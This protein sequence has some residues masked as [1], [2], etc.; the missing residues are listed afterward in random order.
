[1][2]K[3]GGA[4]P[5]KVRGGGTQ[6]GER[7]LES[8]IRLRERD[9]PSFD[10][11]WEQDAELRFVTTSGSTDARG[12]ITPAEHIGKR[13]WE[14]P[15]TEIVNQSW[16]EHRAV[17]D[18][19]LPFRDLLLRRTD[20]DG[21]VHLVSVSGRPMF[22][23]AARFGGYRGIA[24]DVTEHRRVEQL[25]DLEHAVN[26]S[27][28]EA[29][30]A[31]AGLEG[32]IRAVCAVTQWECGRYFRVDE[33]DDVLRFSDAWGIAEPQIGR[34]L[35]ISRELVY[36][37]DEGL[38][39]FAWRSG[40][41]VW[42]SDV[43]KD[44]RAPGSSR[45]AELRGAGVNG[46]FVFPVTAD[47]RTVGV[48]SFGSRKPRTPEKQLLDAVAVIGREL[49]QFLQR[50]HAEQELRSKVSLLSAT[51]EST[52][53]GI[54]VVAPDHR[55]SLFNRRFVEMWG[56]PEEIIASRD[57]ARALE[58]V[59]DQV[60]HPADFIAKIEELYARPGAESFDTI[61]F[62]DGRTFERYSRPQWVA[63]EPVGRVWSFRDVTERKRAE[64]RI[65]VL[66]YQDSLTELP[67]RIL[68]K[69]RIE[70]AT[71]RA[72]R[73]H[74]KVALLFLDIDHFKTI[75]DSLG[76]VAGDA[77]LKTAAVRAR[78]CVRETDT[79]SRQGG[80]EFLIMLTDL[81]DSDAATPVVE[82]L[83]EQFQVPFE[84]EGNELTSS[85]S[86]GVAIYPD[87]GDDFDTLLKKADT[88]MY[89]AKE[90]GR[91]TYRFFDAQMN[92]E[93]VEHLRIRNDL[94]SAVK[95]EE[96]FLH[97][98]PQIDLSSGK[99][100]AAEALVRWNHPRH[101][102]L[103]PQRFIPVAEESGLIIPVGE[104][105]L[106][107]ACRQAAAWRRAGHRELVV[108]VNLS[109]VQFR[110][111]E[112]ERTV[113]AALEESGIEPSMLELELTESILIQDTEATLA[114]VKRLKLLGLKLSIDDFG[115][116]YSSLSYLKRF[117]V[118][119]LKIDQSFIRDLGVDP[120]DAAIVRSI[121]QMAHSLGLRTVAEGVEDEALLRHLRIYRCDEAQG[122]HLGRPLAA[123]DFL[124]YLSRRA[125]SSIGS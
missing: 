90:G 40:E 92:V 113:I 114:T 41:P 116:G 124:T 3:L 23:S 2:P 36:R 53:D 111:S 52:A 42:S 115:T 16:D 5:A 89:R 22:D 8:V 88:A 47:G 100:V 9:A 32:A 87:D 31:S 38:S 55:I 24:W 83:L 68:F 62:K 57:D 66:A 106:R 86:I 56:I 65:R 37:R 94:R 25:R 29:D 43:T 121:I 35:E 34:F 59:L 119:K 123:P 7:G 125:D 102:V 99:V 15:N 58:F 48:M 17:L 39:G 110:R 93:A 11:Y 28:A 77:L 4:A 26:R 84:I 50:K 82:K 105:V 12:G 45:I 109:A 112:L 122:Y 13:R 97:Y 21:G 73:A 63:N 81:P 33:K 107:E 46:A 70:Q 91:N 78:A 14:L 71:A 6:G 95:R 20:A 103:L 108:A 64:E 117:E 85:V 49:G 74:A 51:L 79:L 10:W 44:P 96:L 60:K 120:E 19:R 30:T 101:G 61:E 18:A 75:N 80:D 69:D 1:M 118:D 76:H 67:N 72:D 54:L 104:W 27:L 98:Q